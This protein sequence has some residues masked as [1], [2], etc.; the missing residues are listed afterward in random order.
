MYHAEIA[1]ALGK[2]TPRNPRP[3][4]IKNG[5]HEQPVVFSRTAH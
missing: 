1:K 3:I 5:L 4:A 2:I